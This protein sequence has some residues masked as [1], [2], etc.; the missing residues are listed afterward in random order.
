VPP[1][2]PLTPQTAQI[3]TASVEIKTL[4][5]SGKQVTMAVFRQLY[6]EPLYDHLT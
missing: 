4:T 3:T 6:Q 5:V 1:R 2:R